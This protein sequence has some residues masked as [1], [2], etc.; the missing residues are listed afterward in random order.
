MC[1]TLPANLSPSNGSADALDTNPASSQPD[2]KRIQDAINACPAGQAVKLTKGS[3]GQSAFISGPLTIKSGVTLWIDSGVTLFASRNPADYDNGPGTCGTAT[4]TD[5]KA[6]NPLILADSTVNSGIVGDGKIDGRGGSLLTSGPNAGNRSWWDVAMQNKTQGLSQQNPRL[7]IVKK[8]SNFT[9]YHVAIM[10]SPNFHFTSNGTQG[11]TAWGIKILSPSIVYTKPGYA[12]AAGT[13]PDKVTPA[14]CFTPETVKNT[15][16]FDP[17]VSQN[18]LLTYSYISTGDDHVAVKSGS[19][20]TTTNLNVSHNH[21]YYGHGMSI[22]SETNSGLSNAVIDD[23]VIDGQDSTGSIGLRIKSD[24]SRGGHVDNVTYSNVC[25]RNVRQPLVF[26]AYYSNTTGSLFPNFTNITIKGLHSLGSAKYAGGTLTFAGYETGGN[27]FPIG[28][29]L[30]NVVFDGT[31]PTLAASNNSGSSAAPSATH[32][33]FGPGAVSFASSV[34]QTSAA[35][36]TIAGK[37][38]TSTAVSC[39]SAFVK[40]STMLADAPI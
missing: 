20:G 31:Q 36:V 29:T 27:V 22:G 23:L 5:P 10:N 19:T 11:I 14:T 9:L 16:G 3:G 24:S 34:T 40:M 12:C 6:C 35:D 4:S 39:G 2:A 25:M 17:G 18:V 28:I 33:T 15:D 13:T 30:D 8:G 37:A 32:F 21:L 7:I 38:G 26:D 1:N